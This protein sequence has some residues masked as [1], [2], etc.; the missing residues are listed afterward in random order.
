MGQNPE[1]EKRGAWSNVVRKTRIL[2]WRGDSKYLVDSIKI[3]R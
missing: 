1:N 2:F 3:K